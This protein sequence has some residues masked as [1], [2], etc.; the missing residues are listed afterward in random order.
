MI[1]TGARKSGKT[2][3]L[4]R[5]SPAGFRLL[6]TAS[7]RQCAETDSEWIS[8]DEIGYPETVCPEYCDEILRLME[9]KRLI[10]VVRTQTL[11]FLEELCRRDDVFLVDLDS[12]FGNP[13][14][15]I[16]ASG[17]G[18]RFGDNKLMADFRGKPLLQWTLDATESIFRLRIV[19][20]RHAAVRELCRRQNIDVI[21]HD[22]P[23][24][25]DTVRLGLQAILPDIDSCM[26]CPGDQPLLR[27]D[28][29]ASLALSAFHEKEGI[30]RTAF[31]DAVGSPVLFPAWAFPELL[32]LPEGKGGGFVLKKY[33]GQVHTTPVRDKYELMDIDTPE[34]LTFLAEQSL[35]AQ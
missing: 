4:S 34:D 20:T 33:P 30:W 16:M 7:P 8:I 11:P 2:T 9:K 17:L 3:L 18:R 10:A 25:S 21:F 1:L 26:F 32:T 19:V 6:G 15:V 31:E 23:Y 24:R 28:T 27:W 5:L 14:C 29:V 22:L 13:G 12:P 35:P